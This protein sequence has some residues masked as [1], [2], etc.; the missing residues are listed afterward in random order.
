MLSE[1]AKEN[2]IY[3]VGGSMPEIDE[4]GKYITPLMFLTEKAF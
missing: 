3:L 4:N 2:S 1:L